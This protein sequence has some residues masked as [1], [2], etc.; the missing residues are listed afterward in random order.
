MTVGA[1]LSSQISKALRRHALRTCPPRRLELIRAAANE[2]DYVASPTESLIWSIGIVKASY[3]ER[4]R[5]M[6][7]ASPQISKPVLLLEAL[8][9]FL[10]ASLLWF[11]ASLGVFTSLMPRADGL[12]LVTASMVGP[13]G[14]MCFGELLLGRARVDASFR[15]FIL[16]LLMAWA[17]VVESILPLTSSILWSLPWRDGVL[18]LLFP[19]AAVAHYSLLAYNASPWDTRRPRL[20]S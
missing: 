9:C 1:L 6:S 11:K 8:I 7:I 3:R 10:P 15:A 5:S 2:L 20:A 17:V 4:L 12:L 18:L 14:M 19:L 16:A 13:V